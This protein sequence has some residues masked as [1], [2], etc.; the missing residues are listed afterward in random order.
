MVTGV[1]G[2]GG[3]WSRVYGRRCT[4]MS[5]YLKA[6]G[7]AEDAVEGDGLKLCRGIYFDETGCDIFVI[8]P[9]GGWGM[10]TRIAV[11]GP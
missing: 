1:Y 2:G 4:V 10:R 9:T 5:A 3:A 6:Y 7:D 8:P 11:I